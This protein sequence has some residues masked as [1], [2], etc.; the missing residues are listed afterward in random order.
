M[1]KGINH[2]L[3]WKTTDRLSSRIRDGLTRMKDESIKYLREIFQLQQMDLKLNNTLGIVDV[4][5]R[6]VVDSIK[7]AFRSNLTGME[8]DPTW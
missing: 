8:R 6:F 4:G 5:L 2:H 3:K 7:K 1:S